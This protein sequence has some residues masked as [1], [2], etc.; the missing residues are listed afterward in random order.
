[1]LNEV[2]QP[3][4]NLFAP[5]K[6]DVG[7]EKLGFNEDLKRRRTEDSNLQGRTA[8]AGAAAQIH[9]AGVPRDTAN[10]YFLPENPYNAWSI[11]RF[12]T[13][14]IVSQ[15][16]ANANIARGEPSLFFAQKN[17]RGDP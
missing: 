16:P 17:T 4:R 7:A 12:V 10:R 5:E 14:G 1:M 2:Y 3:V 13:P 8:L 15:H 11:K 9:P 6:V